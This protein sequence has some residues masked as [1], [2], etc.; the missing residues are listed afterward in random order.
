MEGE[1]ITLQ[2]IFVFERTGVRSDGKVSGRFRA[3]GIRPRACEHFT[4]SGIEVPRTMFD[5]VQIVG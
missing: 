1:I 3:T 4:Q 5:H 2:D